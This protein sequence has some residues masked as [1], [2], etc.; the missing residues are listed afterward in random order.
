MSTF[1]STAKMCVLCKRVHEYTQIESTNTFGASDLDLR[2]A[3]MLRSTM[4]LWVEECPFCGYVSRNVS[5]LPD[6]MAEIKQMKAFVSTE[7]YQN[8]EGNVFAN[9]LA[10]KFYKKY[11]LC[12]EFGNKEGACFALLSASWACDDVN[13][14]E[15]SKMCREMALEILKTLKIRGKKKDDFKLQRIDMMRRVGR[16]D[17]V[18]R[19]YSG[20]IYFDKQFKRIV[21]FQIEKS[22]LKDDGCYTIEDV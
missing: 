12:K 4:P 7:S 10:A 2:P 6:E 1:F 16:F 14:K 21:K 17:E 18:I 19:Q 15:K 3:E 8:A 9:G 22:K 20:K 13:D 5:E 11:M